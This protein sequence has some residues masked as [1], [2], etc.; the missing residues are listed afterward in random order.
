MIETAA[1]R[2]S[3]RWRHERR[4]LML[5][6]AIDLIGLLLPFGRSKPVEP[7]VVGPGA[8]EIRVDLGV[9]GAFT[10]RLNQSGWLD[11]EVLAA[12]LLRQ[13]KTLSVLG[14]LTGL[15]L[16]EVLR[17]RRSKFLPREF[18]LAVT[19]DRVVAFALTSWS[20]GDA[21]GTTVAVKIKRGERGSWPRELVR[22]TDRA[23]SPVSTGG[24]L[25][26]GGVERLPV[27]AEDADELL[28]V[29]SA[30]AT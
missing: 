11:D 25:E 12:G 26:L 4:C 2:S 18:V 17:P 22:L 9:P 15:A 5:E 24:I 1:R 20:E 8:S 6:L 27:M 23:S 13:G 28:E 29:L 7:T 21:S 16:I 10:Q 14:I 30:I 19:A 3:T